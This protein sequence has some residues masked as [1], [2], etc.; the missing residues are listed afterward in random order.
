MTEHAKY[1]G[2][3][4]GDA[5]ALG[6]V[7]KQLRVG[8]FGENPDVD[9]GSTPEDAWTEGGLYPWMTAPTALQVR[10]TSADDTAAG[11][12]ARSASAFILSS[13]FVPSIVVTALNGTTAVPLAVAPY[14]I[15]LAQP[16]AW[17]SAG[18]NLGDIIFEDVAPPNTIRAVIPAGVGQSQQAPYTVAANSSLLIKQLYLGVNAIT[19]VADRSANLTTYFK[20]TSGALRLPITITAATGRPYRHDIDP[21]IALP[22]GT[23][24]SLRITKVT[25]NNSSITGA[26]N[27]ILVQN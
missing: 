19:G 6:R 26:W 18:V 16:G 2:L 3:P 23:D 12:G 11:S 4:H 7:A 17:G 27:G 13:T 14:R 1:L 22:A 10:S 8:G 21:P 15:N 24:F 20:F 9:T 25:D 5:V